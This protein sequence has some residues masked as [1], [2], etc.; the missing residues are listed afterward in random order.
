M[1]TGQSFAGA[2]PMAPGRGHAI[3]ANVWW[4]H[5]GVPAT[6]D[7]SSRL[8]EGSDPEQL[9]N[10]LDGCYLQIG[11]HRHRIEIYSVCDQGGHRWVQLGL[12]GH[13]SY[14]ITL[15]VAAGGGVEDTLI[16]L[17]YGTPVSSANFATGSMRVH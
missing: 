10:A 11:G 13:S 4:I 6:P 16:A 1:R 17:E 3:P 5:A 2:G 7:R 14:M 15:K 8:T 9:F 12:V